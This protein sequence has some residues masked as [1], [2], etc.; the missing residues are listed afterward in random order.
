M[1]LVSRLTYDVSRPRPDAGFFAF[2]GTGRDRLPAGRLVRAGRGDADLG[3]A[4][5]V[6]AA[7]L[8]A[9]TEENFPAEIRVDVS[10]DGKT[11]AKAAELTGVRYPGLGKKIVLDLRTVG[12][13]LA[14]RYVRFRFRHPPARKNGSGDVWYRV[15]LPGL[16]LKVGQ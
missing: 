8:T 11:F 16:R 9:G 1:T 3:T 2:G 13:D 14:G 12:S 7:E 5:D 15:C 4:L 6:R 10:V